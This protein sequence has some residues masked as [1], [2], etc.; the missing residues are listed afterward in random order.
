MRALL[1]DF[2]RYEGQLVDRLRAALTAPGFW[3]V[4][5]FRLQQATFSLPLPLRIPAKLVLRPLAFATQVITGVELQSGA[6]IG[7]GLYVGHW[8]GIVVSSKARI[9]AR[10]NLSQGVTLGVAK[11]PDGRWGAPILG[12]RVYVGPGAKI[13][14]PI[15]IGNDVAIG[16]NAVVN[17]D[18][19]DGVTVGGVPAKIISTHGSRGLIELGA[20]DQSPTAPASPAARNEI[21][22]QPARNEVRLESG[23]RAEEHATV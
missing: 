6:R 7:P 13:F 9:G 3:S 23:S 15:R 14:G 8:G 22:G 21:V 2:R 11:G 18:V 1:A 19:P 17:R 4:A 16:A 20:E 5:T 12:E 10:C